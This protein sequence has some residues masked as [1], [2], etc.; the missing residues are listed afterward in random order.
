[1]FDKNKNIKELW[2]HLRELNPNQPSKKS[3]FANIAKENLPESDG[4]KPDFTYLKQYI[5]SK[6][7]D[8]FHF[9]ISLIEDSWVEKPLS[10]FEIK[11]Y[12][13]SWSQCQNT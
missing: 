1:M 8:N 4:S 10:S 11:N 3:F 9:S 6:V 7:S 13:Y 2:K 5:N 12:R